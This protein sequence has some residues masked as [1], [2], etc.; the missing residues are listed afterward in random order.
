M[1]VIAQSVDGDAFEVQ[2]FDE[3]RR[4]L[5]NA[6]VGMAGEEALW[7]VLALPFNYPI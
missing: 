1:K 5:S 6:F 3:L 2:Q 7:L 4:E